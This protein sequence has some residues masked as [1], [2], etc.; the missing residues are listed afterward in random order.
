MSELKSRMEKSVESLKATLA[1]FRT[2]RASPEL[3]N[4]L[5]VSYYGSMVPVKQVA[6]ISVPEPRVIMLNVFDKGGVKDVERA[7]MTSDLGLQPQTDGTIIRLRLPE[8]TEDRRKDLVKQVKK[9]VEDA[10]VSVRNIRRDFVDSIKA[11]E[12]DKSVSEDEAKKKQDDA[13]KT[14]DHYIG[15]LDS[16]AKDKEAEIMTV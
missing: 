3:L 10:K 9:A 2:G 7:I 16:L 1:G 4:R 8:L 13:Q 12:K 11:Q 6:A 5:T 15:I 14:T